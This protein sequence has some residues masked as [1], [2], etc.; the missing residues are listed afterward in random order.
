MGSRGKLGRERVSSRLSPHLAWGNISIR[1]V[2]RALLEARRNADV[3]M[4]RELGAFESR[5]HWHCHFIQRF[6]MECR[7]E[8]EAINRGYQGLE[9]PRNEGHIQAWK[10]GRTGFP[11]VDAAMRCL[12]ATG[13]INF[14]SRSMLVS[15]LCH[16][17]WQD[18]RD[19]A[20]HLAARF[21]DFEPG[22]HYAQ[23]QMQAGVTG[24][25]TVRVY[26]PVKQSREHDAG[27]EFI[28]RW[29]PELAD[30]PAPLI[31]TPWELTP[32]ERLLYAGAGNYPEPLVDPGS[33]GDHARQLL[34]R[35]KK[36]PAVCRERERILARHVEARS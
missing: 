10:A 16:G 3:Y 33:A 4:E 8:F 7:M 21:L 25:N 18:W 19:A 22:I 24:I 36:D 32:M 30:V 5:L 35:M 28:R 12:D 29:V 14:R 27:G 26:N 6:E 34:W 11:L 1:Q 31:H 9:R 23:L 20:E 13:Y 15:F 17:L 2:Y